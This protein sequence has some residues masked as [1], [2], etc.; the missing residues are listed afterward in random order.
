MLGLMCTAVDDGFVLLIGADGA[1][2]VG[3]V[4]VRG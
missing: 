1:R 3:A 4:D 2:M